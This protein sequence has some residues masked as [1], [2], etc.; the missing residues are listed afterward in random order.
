MPDLPE[1]GLEALG[2]ALWGHRHR[3]HPRVE[4]VHEVLLA[5]DRG[6][7]RA[8]AVEHG[9]HLELG[10]LHPR[11][12]QRCRGERLVLPLQVL[13][14]ED[15]VAA[16][17][18][19]ARVEEADSL[20]RFWLLLLGENPFVGEALLSL[21]LGGGRL[22][23]LLRG[24]LRRR[25]VHLNVGGPAMDALNSDVA[26]VPLIPYHLDRVRS[27]IRMQRCSLLV[28]R[29]PLRRWQGPPRLLCG[30]GLQR[31]RGLNGSH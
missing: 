9:E 28:P 12:R 17:E 6:L 29:R 7:A 18:V 24:V 22:W 10:S 25:L 26:D 19:A 13:L 14:A 20:G 16:R 8:V 23:S 11:K 4:L 30:M 3:R 5:V 31:L 15:K 2:L 27:Q 1:V 21:A